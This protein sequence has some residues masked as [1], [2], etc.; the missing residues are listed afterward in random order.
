MPST[1]D[2]VYGV[3]ARIPPGSVATYGQIA[4]HLGMPNGARTVGWAMRHCPAGLP[5]Y[6][7][8][9]SQGK[10]SLH[11]QGLAE[12][13]GLLADEGV[14]MDASGRLNLKRHSWQEI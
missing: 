8:V 1:Y 13:R 11:G 2:L 4:L 14:D 9:N 10:S 3:V 12:Q 6:R 7:V 5:W